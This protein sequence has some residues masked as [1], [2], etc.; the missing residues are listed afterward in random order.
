MACSVFVEEG[1]LT[2]HLDDSYEGTGLDFLRARQVE[3]DQISGLRVSRRMEQP[4]VQAIDMTE[5]T[6]PSTPSTLLYSSSKVILTSSASNPVISNCCI[7]QMPTSP[8]QGS[9]LSAKNRTHSKLF[10][11]FEDAS[12]LARLTSVQYLGDDLFTSC[13]F[14]I[15]RTASDFQNVIVAYTSQ[16]VRHL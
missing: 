14:I 2:H 13:P 10:F 4:T 16:S 6:I 11:A 1:R 8:G 9:G 5:L 15:E 3:G 12:P 7:P